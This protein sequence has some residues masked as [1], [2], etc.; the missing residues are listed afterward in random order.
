MLLVAVPLSCYTLIVCCKW[1]HA[2]AFVVKTTTRHPH[3]ARRSAV[4]TGTRLNSNFESIDGEAPLQELYWLEK[5]STDRDDGAIYGLT[6]DD[7]LL[8][9]DDDNDDDDDDDGSALGKAI[10][11]GKLIICLPGI[12]NPEE[13]ETL[14]SAGW[15]ASQRQATPAARGRSRFSVSDP[16]VFDNDGGGGGGG[17]VVVF[18]AEEILLRVLDYIDEYI[19][20]IYSWLFDPIS[21]EDWTSRQPLNAALEQPDTPPEPFLAETCTNLRDLYM[22]G[23]LEWSEGEPAINIYQ[24]GGYFGAHKDHL[25]LTILIP[26]TSVEDFEGGGTGFWA[27]N[28]AVD[29]NPGDEPDLILKPSPGSALLFG[30]DVTHAG[31]PVSSGVRSVLVCSFSTVT[32]ASNPDRLHGLQAPPKVSANFKGTA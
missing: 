30:G 18:T 26:L 16:I 23:A 24:G 9:G 14:F 25:A 28:R 5:K 22:Q 19:P 3:V 20:S 4:D 29:E 11:E 21:P 27:G 1:H 2:R 32:P 31:M 10:G 13:C 6:D 17:T 15:E 12:A 8:F 7:D